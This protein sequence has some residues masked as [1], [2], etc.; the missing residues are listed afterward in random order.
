MRISSDTVNQETERFTVPHQERNTD[1]REK[2]EEKESDIL[3][4]KT[5][6]EGKKKQRNRAFL[7]SF[8][9]LHLH[10]ASPTT[11]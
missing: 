1:Q 9:P 8:C 5:S 11:H 6:R 10:M 7:I 2:R 4:T 3:E